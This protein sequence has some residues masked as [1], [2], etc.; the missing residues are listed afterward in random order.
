MAVSA[1]AT[2]ATSDGLTS[3]VSVLLRRR[4][5]A[6]V[7]EVMVAVVRLIMGGRAPKATSIAIVTT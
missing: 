4:N 6:Q 3:S 2:P 1:A 7:R 5:G